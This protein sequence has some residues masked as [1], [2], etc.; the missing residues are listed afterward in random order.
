MN[1]LV[2]WRDRDNYPDVWSNR[3]SS[4]FENLMSN[5][6]Y[7]FGDAS[8]VNDD[9]DVVYEVEVPGFNKDNIKV[10][11]N[12]NILTVSGQRE[13]KSKSHAGSRTIHKRLSVDKT[14]NIDA[15][16]EDGILYVT[17]L[18]EKSEEKNIELT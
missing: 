4:I 6:D 1:S 16:I 15:K 17:L 7:F 11:L 8:Y 13:T 12:N 2:K 3:P 14:E 9:G 10:T 18:K 5:F